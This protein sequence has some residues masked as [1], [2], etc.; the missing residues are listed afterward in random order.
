M[1]ERLS[2]PVAS[3]KFGADMEILAINDG[4]VTLVIDTRQRDW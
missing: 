2:K 1:Q 3:C 4:P